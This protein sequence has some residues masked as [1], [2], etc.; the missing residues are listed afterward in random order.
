M[1]SRIGII[2]LGTIGKTHWRVIREVA[3]DDVDRCC[4][5]RAFGC[6]FRPR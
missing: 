1:A 3:A 2:G 6:G 4:R 5:S